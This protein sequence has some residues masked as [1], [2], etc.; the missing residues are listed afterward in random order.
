MGWGWLQSPSQAP[1]LPSTQA[2][3][4]GSAEALPHWPG[5]EGHSG[6]APWTEMGNDKLVRAA[7][8][9]GAGLHLENKKSTHSVWV[10]CAPPPLDRS[11][12]TPHPQGLETQQSHMQQDSL[13]LSPLLQ[14][15]SRVL[16][17]LLH[18]PGPAAE[19]LH[20]YVHSQ[21]SPSLG[22]GRDERIKG[23]WGKEG[24]E[25]WPSG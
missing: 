11:R 3:P 22:P 15:Y 4:P 14:G 2:A 8:G 7:R 9:A 10:Q 20:T 23:K 17:A 18:L 5:C 12:C 21:N 13:L 16:S 24:L 19:H 6:A 25:R 1:L